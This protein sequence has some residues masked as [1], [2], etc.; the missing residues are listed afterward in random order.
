VELNRD[1]L[2]RLPLA[3][4]I[5]I[6]ENAQRKPLTQS[7]VAIEQQRILAQLRKHKT[8]GTRNDLTT[9]AKDFAQVETKRLT[10]IVGEL[11]NESDRQVEKRLAIVAAA[12][13]EPERFGKLV[14]D[15]DRTGKIDRAYKLLR[16]AQ[17][18]EAYQAR[19]EQG[20]K[21]D[22]LLALA[23]TG[24]RAAV[25]LADPPWPWET[26]SETGKIWTSAD[27][28]FA[29]MSLADVAA[30]GARYVTPLAADHCV[31]FLWATWPWIVRGEV[32]EIIRAWGFEPST[33]A[34]VWI[35]TNANGEGLHWGNGYWT[36]SNSEPCLLALRGSPLR[37]GADVHQV[38]M[39]PVGEHSAKPD[40]VYERIERL[41]AG[42][43]L[44]LFARKLRPGW[45]CWGDEVPWTAPAADYDAADDF[46]KSIDA[47]Y[48]AVRERVKNGGPGWPQQDC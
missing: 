3:L 26:F 6:E 45:M 39:A 30:F 2:R 15:M 38:I 42:P 5:E 28:H 4:R 41:V 18:R 8:P 16:I 31:L 40:E 1:V 33:D 27:N 37:L 10:K 47:C 29:P 20:G 43:Y 24:Y 23:A 36:R 17:V 22:D 32:S 12:E 14:A 35:K 13:A 11:F 48:E 7:E 9:P 25:V 19:R 34:F 21:V 46:A 44:E